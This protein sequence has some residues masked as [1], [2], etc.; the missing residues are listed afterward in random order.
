MTAPSTSPTQRSLAYL[1]EQGYTVAIVEHWNPH[2]RCRVDLFGC[3][4]LVAIRSDVPGVLGVQ[5]TS[6]TNQAARRTKLLESG[7]LSTWL[8]AQNR[9][10]VHGWAKEGPRGERKRWAVTVWEAAP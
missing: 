5:T 6:R 8:A 2:A 9:A 7:H 10:H 1:R 4:D 3:F